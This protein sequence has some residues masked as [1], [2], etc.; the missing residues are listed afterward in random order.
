MEVLEQRLNFST[1]MH[2]K[3]QNNPATTVMPQP[4]PPDS[5]CCCCCGD[6]SSG[7]GSSSGNSGKPS[8]SKE[9]LTMGN[10]FQASAGMLGGGSSDDPVVVMKFALE[11]SLS[12][13]GEAAY[14]RFDVTIGSAATYSIYYSPSIGGFRDQSNGE[15][16]ALFGIPVSANNLTSGTYN[17][18][19]KE[20]LY[21]ASDS[22]NPLGTSYIDTS[23]PNDPAPPTETHETFHYAPLHIVNRTQSPFGDG[24][25]LPGLDQLQIQRATINGVSTGQPEGVSLVTGNNQVIWFGSPQSS[26]GTTTY[27]REGNPYNF[28]TLIE[29][30]TTD[31]IQNPR[32]GGGSQTL[33]GDHYVL[34]DPDGTKHYFDAGGTLVG[35]KDRNEN[36]TSYFLYNSGKLD[37][38]TDEFGRVT[39]FQYNTASGP[40]AGLISSITDYWD[41]VS[42]HETT[43]VSQ[44]TSYNYVVSGSSITSMTMSQPAPT[45]L[46]SPL[47]T[48]NYNSQGQVTSVVDPL[49]QE[50][51][52]TYDHVGLV[53][54][55]DRPDG[56]VT[57]VNTLES[58]VVPTSGGTSDTDLAIPA[59]YDDN[60][61]FGLIHTDSSDNTT[62][63]SETVN[64]NQTLVIRALFGGDG[65]ITPDPDPYSNVALSSDSDGNVTTYSYDFSNGVLSSVSPPT[66]GGIQS[67]QLGT[68]YGYAGSNFGL[69]TSILQ[70][71]G[72]G[73]QTS[74]TL[75][76][77]TSYNQLNSIS[78]GTHTT[79]YFIGDSYQTTPNGDHG[80]VLSSTQYAGS[81][82]LPQTTYYTYTT[83]AIDEPAGIPKGLLKSVTDPSGNIT[84]YAY[85]PN[86]HWKVSSVTTAFNTPEASTT[87]YSYDSRDRVTDVV[88]GNN[89]DTHYVYNDLDQVTDRYDPDPTTGTFNLTTSPHWQFYYDAA[90]NQTYTVDPNNNVTQQVYDSQHRVTQV[91]QPMPTGT[92]VTITKDDSDPNV[93]GSYTATYSGNW[94]Q[95]SVPGA[96]GGHVIATDPGG[97]TATL[98]FSGLNSTK[99]IVL[100]RWM[101][102]ASS[103]TAYDSAAQWQVFGNTSATALT[104]VPVNLNQPVQGMPD[105]GSPSYTWQSLGAY[106]PYT[107]GGISSLTIKL[108]N[109]AGGA[110]N[111]D[112]IRLV[113]AGPVTTNTYDTNQDLHTVTDPMGNVTTYG[114]DSMNRLQTLTQPVPGPSLTSPVTTYGYN[115]LDWLTSTKDPNNHTTLYRHDNAGNVVA[116]ANIDDS[117]HT[118]LTADFYSGGAT[119]NSIG[120]Q[121]V[122][123][124]GYL[125]GR[126]DSTINFADASSFTATGLQPST[127]DFWAHWSGAIDITNNTTGPVSFDLQ[128]GST[129]LAS[130]QI[131]DGSLIYANTASSLILAP[132]WHWID[133]YY[134]HRHDV[135]SGNEG[136]T[137]Q[138]DLSGGNNFVAVPTGVLRPAD[139]VHYDSTGRVD[140]TTD[141]MGRRRT[142]A[143][144]NLDNLVSVTAPDPDGLTGPLSGSQTTYQYDANNNLVATTDPLG[145]TGNDNDFWRHTTLTAYDELNRPIYQIQPISSPTASP[146]ILTTSLSGTST[147]GGSEAAAES[148]STTKTY[149]VLVSWTGET[150]QGT[151]TTYDANTHLLV[152]DGS[153]TTLRTTRVDMNQ[154]TYGVSLDGSNWML[155]GAFKSQTGTLNVQLTDDDNNGNLSAAT[156]RLVE[157]GA[158]T[159]MTYDNNGN[160]LTLTDP[161]GNKTTW[162]YDHLDRMKT[163]MNPR[164]KTR[165]FWYDADGNLVEKEDRLNQFTFYDYDRLNRQID[166]RWRGTAPNSSDLHTISYAYNADGWVTSALD[167]PGY[168]GFPNTPTVSD[169][170]SY[171]NLGRATTASQAISGVSAT[172]TQAF[173]SNSNRTSVALSG[174]WD[175]GNSSGTLLTNSYQYDAVNRMTSVAQTAGVYWY[176][177][178]RADFTY[179][180]AGQFNTINRSDSSDGTHWNLSVQSTYGY[181]GA[182]RIKSLVYT[183][184][185]GTTTYAGYGLQ[186]DDANRLTQLTNT[187]HTADTRNYAY[188]N[189]SQLTDVGYAGQAAT[190]DNEAYRYDPNGNRTTATVS[191]TTT[192]YALETTGDNRLHSDGTYTYTYDDEGNLTQKTKNDGSYTMYKYDQRNRLIEVE[193]FDSTGQNITANVVYVYDAFDRLVNRQDLVGFGGQALDQFYVYDGNQILFTFS[194]GVDWPS[195]DYLPTANYLWGPAVD[196]ALA[197]DDTISGTTGWAITDQQNSV[198]GFAG[199]GSLT[200][201]ENYTAYGLRTWGTLYVPQIAGYTGRFYDQQTGLQWN[202]GQAFVGMPGGWSP[203]VEDTG[204]WYN[205]SLGR[206]M[207]EDPTGF[208]DGSNPDIY[209]HND[210]VNYVDPSG[211]L[212]VGVRQNKPPYNPPQGYKWWFYPG[213]GKAHWML[214]PPTAVAPNNYP[215]QGILTGCGRRVAPPAWQYFYDNSPTAQWSATI[216]IGAGLAAF[217]LWGLGFTGAGSIG[218]GTYGGFGAYGGGSFHVIVGTNGL[219]WE[220]LGY[221]GAMRVY[222]QDPS[223]WNQWFVIP[224]IPLR[225]PGFPAWMLNT[226]GTVS[227]CVDLALKTVF[228][229]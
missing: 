206:W 112:G 8:G 111:W 89:G 118:G 98:T 115:S 137:L 218:V 12:E 224:G 105:G 56:S 17:W 184:A 14:I 92:P 139:Q 34:T 158:V 107:S 52:V 1:Y 80:S 100:V 110:L 174:V 195:D 95:T 222:Q 227:S 165:T 5:C 38:V 226:G 83:G 155:V 143:Y 203:F 59:K 190:N 172:L 96:T 6:S 177:D 36:V 50:T 175:Y 130:L 194:G 197:Q 75:S 199:G 157:V 66:A 109:G 54:E 160:R 53:Q 170:F 69:P 146:Q 71:D 7:G 26:G 27:S 189:W 131:D 196:M 21:T 171:D 168:A 88:D 212:G 22:V 149:A 72:N 208:A 23:D 15:Y 140:Y 138:Y 191:G 127:T 86:H 33:S 103:G 121:P 47:T 102:S 97:G 25:Y 43:G 167:W 73:G 24:W 45:G 49:G 30:S 29:T 134:R 169:T 179:D 32:S 136:I 58:Q 85:D 60:F 35:V 113:T 161:D 207:G 192:N 159:S 63:E 70:P 133:A 126:A 183:N 186:Y 91:I 147:F 11:D 65:Q 51:R 219:W 132:G 173:D 210:P 211:L 221:A 152:Q 205:S 229:S 202:G 39:K 16:Q 163:E 129:S 90:G 225:D 220:A 41:A 151:N 228:G 4:M 10:A 119:V 76:Y 116:T 13:L 150:G 67:S 44:K 108:S 114:Y 46:A 117:T 20:G 122:T 42:D 3:G 148:V 74:E 99:Y 156:V 125:T 153:S 187:V 181:D 61:D 217:G 214:V 120:Y 144:D 81:N 57:T 200:N 106:S 178:H 84:K 2:Y 198:Q 101:P 64:G 55:I 180:A 128:T 68:T 37:T 18:T 185:A 213:P 141:M 201:A 162:T 145:Q 188:D 77:D 93:A 182:G 123:F 166:E 40:T 48:Y 223:M 9:P 215:N 62:L 176:Y 87:T 104:T 154:P 204:R 209:A 124:S 79:T 216:G 94:S 28:S 142:N 19:V 164:G 82:T 135:D 31:V 78:D 193:S